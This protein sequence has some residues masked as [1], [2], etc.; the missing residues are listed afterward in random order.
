[1]KD[2]ATSRRRWRIGALADATGLTVRTLHHYE[3]IGLLAAAARSE[4][5]QRLYDEDDV[6]RLYRIRALRDLGLSLGDIRRMLKNDRAALGDVLRAHRARVDAEIEQLR[7]LRSL[8]DHACADADRDVGP[9]E[10]LATIEAM[11]RIVRRSDARRKKGVAPGD[12]GARWREL[13]DRLRACMKAGEAPSAP[14]PRAVA[15]AV[16]ARID[17]FAGGDRATLEAL[18]HLRRLD[19]PED[20]AGWTPAL[21]RYLN[22]SL[23]S[24]AEKER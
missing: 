22:Q 17:E 6:R 24:L 10:V 13:G 20:F 5:R 11:S 23:A 8:L 3:H 2:R 15:R 4:G 18:A 1:M 12:N 9:D 16:Q 14:R 21:M 19:P 7:K